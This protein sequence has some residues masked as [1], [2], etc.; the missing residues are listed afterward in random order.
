MPVLLWSPTASI[1]CNPF[2]TRYCYDPAAKNVYH[3]A[4]HAADITATVAHFVTVDAVSDIL[5]A[6][7]MGMPISRE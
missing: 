2:Q 1:S 5:E 7:D 4:L 6:G 3:N